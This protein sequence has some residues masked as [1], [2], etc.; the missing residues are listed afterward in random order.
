[1][2]ARGVRIVVGEG[3]STRRGL[4]RFVLDGEG[5]DVVAEAATTAELARLMATHRPAVVVLDDDI[6]ATAVG[7][8]N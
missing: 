5:Y 3:P 1:M 2:S 8:I 6:G 4:L 7:M